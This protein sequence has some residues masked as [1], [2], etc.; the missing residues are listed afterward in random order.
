MKNI[1][2]INTLLILSTT[3]Y[4]LLAKEA[5]TLQLNNTLSNTVAQRETDIYKIS[6]LSG[7]TIKATLDNLT[8]DADLYIEIGSLPLSTSSVCGSVNIEAQ[9]D[10]CSVTLTKDADV[11]IH[12]HGYEATNYQITAST[13]TVP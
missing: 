12:V 3:P 7:Q 6:A 2:F 10:S 13:H 9:A 4:P 5:T 11:Y 8:A 1:F